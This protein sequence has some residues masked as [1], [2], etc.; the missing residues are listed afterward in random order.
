MNKRLYPISEDFFNAHINPLIKKRY[1]K[2]GRPQKVSNYQ[3]F[4]AALYVLRT[5]I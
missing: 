5:G 3:V 2:A 4:C 1:F